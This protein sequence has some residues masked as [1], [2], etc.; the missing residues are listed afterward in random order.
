M[1]GAT[2]LEKSGKFLIFIS[3]HTPH[4]GRDDTGVRLPTPET[5]FYSHAPCGARLEF[6]EWGEKNNEFLLTRPMRGATGH[7]DEYVQEM[8]I[9]THTP[10][11]G[12]D[13]TRQAQA[14]NAADFYSHAP[15]GA[16]RE[17]L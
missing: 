1:R 2:Q 16:R 15:C 17:E 9:S 8:M 6:L 11:A 14:F 10:H 4:A 12:R 3:T 13:N 7:M 5:D